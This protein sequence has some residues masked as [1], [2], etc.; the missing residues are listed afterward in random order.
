MK[1]NNRVLNDAS[2]IAKLMAEWDHAVRQAS[3]P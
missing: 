2:F 3:A 1:W